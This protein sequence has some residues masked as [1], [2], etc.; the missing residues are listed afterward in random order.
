MYLLLTLDHRFH[1]TPNG[2]VWTETT[3]TYSFYQ[4]YLEVFDHVRVLARIRDVTSVPPHWQQA[5]GEGVSFVAVPYYVGPIQYL[6]QAYR[7]NQAIRNAFCV[8]DAAIMR[9][10]S[11]IANHLYNLLKKNNYPYGVEVIGD[12]YDVFAPGSV[13]H[14][15]RAFFRWFFPRQLRQQCARA[16][17]TAYVTE[18]TLQRRYPPAQSAF[19]TH[20]SSVELPDGAFV[21]V[22]RLPPQAMDRLTII[23]VG[24]MDQ[25]YKAPNV[26]I[27]AVAICV[28]QGLNLQLVLVGDGKHRAELEGKAADLGLGERVSFLGWLPAGDAVRAELDRADLFIL[29]S[30]QEGL[31]R[32]TIE[33][34]ARGLPC[35]GSTVGGFP[36]LLPPEDMVPPGDVTALAQKI[37]GVVINPQRMAAM[38]A[39]NL[40]KAREYREEILRQRRINFYFYLREKTE[41]WLKIHSKIGAQNLEVI[42]VN[43]MR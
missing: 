40:E 29:P 17:A 1:R 21:A 6:F 16:C 7:V 19:S 5:D 20:Y 43:K 26:L 9:V 41:E 31:P 33:A 11:Q 38:S 15:L 23:T 8:G 10:S 27:D 2:A 24:T 28:G 36:E 32:A 3:F 25:L 37:I 18:Y 34:M 39:R 35:I 14:P 12:P 42:S 13:K 4:R 22:P 30:Y